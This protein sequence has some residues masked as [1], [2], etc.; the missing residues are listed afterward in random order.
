MKQK[1]IILSCARSC[2][3]F[4]LTSDAH[5]ARTLQ[6]FGKAAKPQAA[7]PLHSSFGQL[8]ERAPEM[9]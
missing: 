9:F 3:I 1:S 5:T 2:F 8:L 6:E 4:T 7:L